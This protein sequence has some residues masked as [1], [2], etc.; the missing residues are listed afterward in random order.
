MCWGDKPAPPSGNSAGANPPGCSVQPCNDPCTT[1]TFTSREVSTSVSE[2]ISNAPARYSRWNNTF[3]W[4]VKFS[5]LPS[6][7]PCAVTVT[8]KIKVTGTITPAQKTAWKNAIE[9]KWNGKAK[10]VCPDPACA[11]ACPGGYPISVVVQYVTSGEHY[12]VT[13]NNPA[14]GG[15]T[16]APSG[17]YGV[18]GTLRMD[19]WGVNDT[20]D[21]PHEFGHMLGNVEE[22]FTTNRVDYTNGGR[23]AGYR[24]ASGGI[25]NNPAN[26]PLPRNYTLIAQQAGAAMGLT[27]T[28]QAA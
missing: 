12:A 22:Y 18:G 24:D 6:R 5:V 23:Q 20:T 9:G 25:M 7:S 21:I 16:V 27:C 26:D 17:T 1:R 28:P 14:S 2:T 10:L 19:I 13:A 11:A 3:G 15:S 8:V 4:D